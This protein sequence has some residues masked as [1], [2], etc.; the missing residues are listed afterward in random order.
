MTTQINTQK[1]FL[2]QANDGLVQIFEDKIKELRSDTQYLCH[3]KFK[4]RQKEWNAFLLP[5]IQEKE[6]EIKKFNWH[7]SRITNYVQEKPNKNYL[8]AEEILEQIDIV[9]LLGTYTKLTKT[10]G[11]E[12]KGRCIFHNERTPSFFVN[13]QKGL[14]HC[15]GCGASGNAANFFMQHQS[16]NFRDALKELKHH[17]L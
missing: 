8:N 11:D 17:C 12:H 10:N 15:F 5:I 13:R 9:D 6:K 3:P 16:M 2:E 14:Y 1:I 7:I 4:K